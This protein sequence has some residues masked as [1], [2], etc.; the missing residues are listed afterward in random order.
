MAGKAP[1][2][3]GR[4][5]TGSLPGRASGRLSRGIASTGLAIVLLVS[6]AAAAIAGCG[7]SGTPS[8]SP[9]AQPP[10]QGAQ[11]CAWPTLYSVQSINADNPDSAA[12]V[13]GQPI[14]ADP[15]TTI[16]IAG[17]FPDAR[18][19]SLS[20]YTPYGNAFTANGV[21]SSLPD[22]RIRPQPGSQNPWQQTAQPGGSFAV[23]ISASATPNQGNVLPMPAGTSG[24]HPGYL[25]YRVYLPTGGNASV[26][27][28]ALTITEG[29]TAH[30]LAECAT[31]TTPVKAE[32]APAS[33]SGTPAGTPTTAP[34]A[35]RFYKPPLTGGGAN[36]DSDYVWAYFV[37]PAATD[38]VVVTAK[39]P[40]SPPGSHPTPWPDPKDDMRY[41]SMCLVVGTASL[42]TVANTLA[43][44]T[45]DYGCRADDATKVDANG[46]YT[47]VIGTET[48]RAAIERLPGVTFLPF[49]STASTPLYLLL[50]RN[51]LVSTPFAQSVQNVTQTQNPAAAA[52]A[53]GPYYPQM[54]TCPLTTLTTG[55][56]QACLSGQ[57]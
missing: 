37:R 12:V 50:L 3:A 28:P 36:A 27:P 32:P 15:N 57:S 10:A 26:Q 2:S 38:V 55:G 23:T 51:T 18:Y 24:Q 8:T 44:G 34:P 42:P 20:V 29:H 48:Q 1:S 19:A 25:V 5:R 6:V 40:T 11:N 43:N 22:Y 16:Q 53:M 47:Y 41:W 33:T 30:L 35:S 39:A 49:S 14:V 46:D 31:H 45:T 9:S 56:P 4:E 17:K 54:S 52:A 7:G 21:S 13:W